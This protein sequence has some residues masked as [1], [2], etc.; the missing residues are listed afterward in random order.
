[1]QDRVGQGSGLALRGKC[2]GATPLTDHMFAS[3]KHCTASASIPEEGGGGN[4]L[5]ESGWTD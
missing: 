5:C 3:D 1:M 4:F 2:M